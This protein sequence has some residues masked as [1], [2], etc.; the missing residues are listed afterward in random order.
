MNVLTVHNFYREPGGEDRVVENES[1]LLTRHGHRVVQY[2]PDNDTIDQINPITLAG[3]TVWNRQ[4]YKDIR[5]LI[6]RESIDVM[7][8]HN[9]LPLASPSV[10]Y[11]AAEEG[12]P[13]VQTLHNYRLLCPNA[14]CFRGTTPCVECITSDSLMP[15]V[16]HKCYRGSTAATAAVATMLQVHR[17]AGTWQDKIDAYIAPSAFAR[18]LFVAGGL[19][20]DRM[21]VKPHFVDAD[22]GVG[23]GGD[24]AIFV[25][26]L[27]P[28]K[29]IDTMLA[30]WSQLHM[31]MPLVIVGDGPLAPAVADAV[32]RCA[33]ITW[34]GR[35][36]H[37]DVQRL[38]G[39]AAVLVFPSVVFETFG[40]VIIEAYASGT[41]VISSSG[42][43]G[44]E[45]VRAEE[46]GLHIAPGDAASLITQVEWLLAHPHRLSAMRTAARS[47]YET[48]FTAR[49][50]Y[51]QLMNIYARALQKNTAK[52]SAA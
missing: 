1:A 28:E 51:R 46:T 43:A 30:A 25:G 29:G 10:Y 11:A 20:D 9:T 38:I 50:N 22:P 8:V 42:G 44:A 27:S 52:E 47:M 18:T 15:A 37:A 31:R 33:G 16:R 34:L 3:M 39:G 19:P 4:S 36:P 13:V 7:H 49:T 21:F 5:A 24:Y 14:L 48:R 41:P 26:R 17:T 2:T 32:R 45:L 23:P 12:V 6:A 40:Q 35:Q